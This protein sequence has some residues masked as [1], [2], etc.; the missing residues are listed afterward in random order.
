MVYAFASLKTFYVL[1]V[2]GSLASTDEPWNPAKQEDG[3]YWWPENRLY[4]MFF[5]I[6]DI[7]ITLFYF[8]VFL[9]TIRIL[10][11]GHVER[12]FNPIMPSS[13]SGK[14]MRNL[15]LIIVLGGYIAGMSFNCYMYQADRISYDDYV[16]SIYIAQ[17]AYSAFCPIALFFTMLKYRK[18]TFVNSKFKA[19]FSSLLITMFIWSGVKIYRG[20]HGLY[21]RDLIFDMLA[22]T[23]VRNLVGEG[24]LF[25]I[26]YLLPYILL[27]S[28]HSTFFLS[29][30]ENGGFRELKTKLAA[31]SAE[32]SGLEDSKFPPKAPTKIKA[33]I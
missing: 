25:F 10:K 29:Y 8:T 19:A 15:L 4:R 1:A 27:I 28:I 14:F 7:L 26:S 3:S 13:T 23:E 22:E 33:M 20:I 2:L 16:F 18:T 31:S 5:G 9:Q 24:I 17:I 6:I 32:N 11:E 30:K 21:Q 12:G